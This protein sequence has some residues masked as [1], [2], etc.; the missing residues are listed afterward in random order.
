MMHRHK[1]LY[2]IICTCRQAASSYPPAFHNVIMCDLKLIFYCMLILE[3]FYYYYS[4][5]S[6]NTQHF[7]KAQELLPT[8]SRMSWLSIFSY[9]TRISVVLFPIA[10]LDEFT[11]D[12]TRSSGRTRKI[13]L[14]KAGLQQEQFSTY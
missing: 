12:R 10:Q 11:G 7:L 13:D 1:Y 5:A 4:L 3:L 6:K 8:S 9:F 14:K 2:H